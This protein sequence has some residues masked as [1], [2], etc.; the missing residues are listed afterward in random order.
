MAV[1][2]KP[3]FFTVEF[4]PEELAERSVIAGTPP[5]LQIYKRDQ[6]VE[7]IE[8]KAYY[9][10]LLC[11]KLG[12]ALP[13]KPEFKV[14]TALKHF[15]QSKIHKAF[16]QCSHGIGCSCTFADADL[17]LGSPLIFNAKVK[18]SEC[19]KEP[20][21]SSEVP[22]PNET[23]TTTTSSSAAHS[24]ATVPTPP[25]SIPLFA[26]APLA[27]LPSANNAQAD[28]FTATLNGLL[29]NFRDEV[30]NFHEA[31]ASDPDPMV[32]FSAGKV[33]FVQGLLAAVHSSLRSVNEVPLQQSE[34]TTSQG[35]SQQRN[36][37][38]V[39]SAAAQRLRNQRLGKR[40]QPQ[41]QND[42]N[43]QDEEPEQEPAKKTKNSGSGK[44]TGN[45]R[46]AKAGGNKKK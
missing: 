25:A 10:D 46:G 16:L 28:E 18:C 33:V 42:E 36:A 32:A 31:H 6:S 45:K 14:S 19:L 35:T 3:R 23:T 30:L 37:N 38:D 43:E 11:E 22:E 2:I 17:K 26:P 21:S 1:K 27:A 12:K 20:S 24:S 15:P 9:S 8:G 41:D 40:A 34:P 7:K 29:Q 5:T 39:L 4:S 13:A 44:G